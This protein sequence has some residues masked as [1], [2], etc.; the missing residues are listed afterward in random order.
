MKKL[1]LILLLTYPISTYSQDWSLNY[2]IGYGTYKLDDI[3]KIQ[4]SMLGRYGLKE[5]DNFPGYFTH[6]LSIGFVR[7]SQLIGTNFSY[8]TTGGRLH[9]ADYSGSYTVDLVMNGYRLGLFYRYYSEFSKIIF[10][11]Q[12]GTGALFSNL[13]INEQVKINSESE[14]EVNRLKG[15]GIYLEPSVGVKYNF[16]K[17]VHF[18]LGGGYEADLLGTLKFSDQKTTL[19]ARWNGFRFYAGLDYVF[20]TQKKSSNE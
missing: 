10:Y 2:S 1:I 8:L 12:L 13:R 15:T 20:P 9:R 18:T 7:G 6:S 19:K 5:T 17:W 4:Q 16:N 14:G 11:E 3:K